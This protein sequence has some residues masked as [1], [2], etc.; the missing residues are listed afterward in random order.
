MVTYFHANP[1]CSLD[2]KLGK[3]LKFG[4]TLSLQSRGRFDGTGFVV[5]LIRTH[6]ILS[7]IE[8]QA[9][10][11][12]SCGNQFAKCVEA[13]AIITEAWG[14][15]ILSE[16]D[17][18]R[19]LQNAVDKLVN[20]D[21]TIL[22]ADEIRLLVGSLNAAKLWNSKFDSQIKVIRSFLVA[23]HDIKRLFAYASILKMSETTSVRDP[24]R[25]TGRL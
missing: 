20:M 5:D 25:V 12:R 16:G 11:L 18:N 24:T 15:E 9:A 2:T 19:L 7:A 3:L 6:N 22:H 17:M 21:L 8:S 13:S 23:L 4:E 10:T 14:G 1:P